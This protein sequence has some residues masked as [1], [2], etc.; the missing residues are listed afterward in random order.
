MAF[1]AAMITFAT[2]VIALS[3]Y[4]FAQGAGETP[5]KPEFTYCSDASESVLELRYSGGMNAN[6]DPAPFVKVTCDGVVLVHWPKYTKK[7]GDYVLKLSR[8]ELESLLANFAQDQ[9]LVLEPSNIRAMAAR[10]QVQ[11]GP[12]ELPQDHGAITIV[13]MRFERVSSS[14]PD[15]APLTNV[16]QRLSLPT[17]AVEASSR[18]AMA[19]L[20]NLAVGIKE[21][22]ALAKRPDLIKVPGNNE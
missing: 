12:V 16:D 8:E 9:L 5:T 3:S 1:P 18:A 14:V 7:A 13:D 10:V 19:P 11:A 22:E 4:A 20:R 6:P 17:A 21:I 15:A 2:L